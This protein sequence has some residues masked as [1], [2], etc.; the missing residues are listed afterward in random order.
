MDSTIV[1]APAAAG[2]CRHCQRLVLQGVD[3]LPDGDGWSH[4]QCPGRDR[5]EKISKRRQ[6]KHVAKKGGP[7]KKAA[8]VVATRPDGRRVIQ[9]RMEGRCPLCSR[10]VAVGD[11]LVQD[12]VLHS[13]VHDGCL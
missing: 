3:A 9:A 4:A 5:A 10:P 6:A 8:P 13:W 11:F 2:I 12:D 7:R 1:P